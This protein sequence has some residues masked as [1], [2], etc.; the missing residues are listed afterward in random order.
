MPWCGWSVGACRMRFPFTHL[1]APSR[2]DLPSV[3]HQLGHTGG[4]T[5]PAGGWAMWAWV[6]RRA[7]RSWLI[8]ADLHRVHVIA[9]GTPKGRQ[10][11][12]RKPPP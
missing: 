8:E 2:W 3:R 12:G 5:S 10:D 7:S 11:T 9:T 6:R 4:T 1:G